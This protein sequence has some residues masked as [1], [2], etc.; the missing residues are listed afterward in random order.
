MRKGDRVLVTGARGFI[1]KRVVAELLIAG[2][3]VVGTVRTP[4]AADEVRSAVA[5]AVDP[6]GRL[7]FVEADL[8]SDRN[9]AEAASGCRFVL[10]VA[11]PYSLSQPRN[12]DDFIRPAREGTLRVLKAAREA[13][14]E[15]MVLTSSV[16]AIT[17]G[18][19]DKT[20]FDETDWSDTG[21]RRIAPYY[22]SKTL[23]ERAAWDFV[24]ENGGPEL[25]ALNPAQVFGPP[26]D[27]HFGTSADILLPLLRGR[28]PAVARY[29]LPVVDVR[30]VAKALVLAMVT[31]TAAGQRIILASD[32]VWLKDIADY[33][34]EA[35]PK[36]RRIPRR[37]L[38][39]PV[40]RVASLVMPG[41]RLVRPDIGR[42]WRISHEKAERLLGMSFR[43]AREAIVSMADALIAGGGVSSS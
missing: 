2:Y 12:P 3:E 13:G 19:F 4:E 8:L 33:L 36:F 37:V 42:T 30:D 39:D 20:D 27:G 10:H 31:P 28:Y 1:A 22:L 34:S 26:L 5:M 40:A 6:A 23:A 43:S 32:F 29:G 38:P 7:S 25:V 14:A 24:A 35:Y 9:W 11:S 15:R 21:S 16:A 17:A 41:L 18:R